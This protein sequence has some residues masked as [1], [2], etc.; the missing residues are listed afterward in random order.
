[1]LPIYAGACGHVRCVDGRFLG[2]EAGQKQRPE[3]VAKQAQPQIPVLEQWL[4]GLTLSEEEKQKIAGIQ[5]EFAPL[6]V[7]LQQRNREI[8]TEE[9]W[10]KR[11]E[12]A[13]KGKAE[14]KSQEEI[15]KLQAEGVE[16]KPEQRKP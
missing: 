11:Q 8:F 2:P 3:K 10:K 1:M 16:L 4:K 6:F 14:G 15:A 13:A 12:I 9:Q 5:K 7:K